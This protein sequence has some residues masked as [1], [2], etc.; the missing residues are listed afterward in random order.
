ML[1]PTSRGVA[2]YQDKVFLAAGEAAL[3]ALDAKTGKRVWT[4]KVEDNRKGYYMSLAPL[5]ADGK[6]IVGASGGE[7]GVRGF[8]AAF[9]VDTGQRAVANLTPCPRQVN[10]AARPGRRAISGRLA[11]DRSGSPATTTPKP[12]W[13]SGAP[14]TAVPGWAISVLATIF[15]PRRQSRSTSAPARSRVI[16]STIPNESWDWDEVSPPILVDYQRNGRT[17]KGL[18]DVARDGYLW[19]LERTDGEIN[20]R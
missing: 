20:F 6:V 3:V 19:F 2:L 17:I 10:L 14:A 12:T 4:T 16:T 7:L 1:H 9:D 8:V 11:A 5:I 15:T 13:R 18:I